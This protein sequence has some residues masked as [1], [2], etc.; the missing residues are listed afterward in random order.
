[1]P[2]AALAGAGAATLTLGVAAGVQALVHKFDSD[3]DVPPPRLPRYNDGFVHT[4][5]S[6]APPA[7]GVSVV[8]VFW[9]TTLSPAARRS[10][11]DLYLYGWALYQDHTTTLVVAGGVQ[12]RP[13]A[14][15]AGA[16][17]LGTLAAEGG[18]HAHRAAYALEVRCTGDTLAWA[19]RHDSGAPRTMSWVHYTP[20]DV[21]RG[22]WLDAAA[23]PPDRTLAPTRLEHLLAMDPARWAE[24]GDP[25]APRPGEAWR[26]AVRRMNMARYVLSPPAT[27]SAV[28][29]AAVL[30]ALSH[31]VAAARAAAPYSAAAHAVA[32]RLAL[33]ESAPRYWRADAQVRRDL[34]AGRLPT[35]PG[36]QT[37]ALVLGHDVSAA[38]LD[39]ALGFALQHV[40]TA[41]GS[42]LAAALQ[43]VAPWL[44]SAAFHTVFAWLVQW[45][46]GIKLN[47]ALASFL[48]DALGTLAGWHDVH[49]VRAASAHAHNAVA[50]SAALAPW[51]GASGVLALWADVWRVLTLHARVL[52]EMLRRA[53]RAMW[54]AAS[55]LFDV[56]RGKKRNPLHGGRLDD[57]EYHVDQLFLGTML[58]TMLVF[59]FPTVQLFFWACAAA[60]VGAEVVH[61]LLCTAARAI[62]GVP[63]YAALV[64]RVALARWADD[65]ALVRHGGAWRVVPQGAPR[66]P[67]APGATWAAPAR[68][69][70]RLVWCALRGVQL[71]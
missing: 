29:L 24:W 17:V 60:W 15:P 55:E 71:P 34:R 23:R 8:R 7:P 31:A 37:A 38:V 13:D 45:P 48:R 16:H 44:G 52:Y 41:R 54:A 22:H 43:R 53:Y 46:L 56:F 58:F 36:L 12:A 4:P 32:L 63:L 51:L 14:L 27:S 6:C 30:D 66:A 21:L 33:L 50:L 42:D 28:P 57:A 18:Y 67:D 35:R 59:L 62:P 64:Q 1:M 2:R 65:V 47:A 61:A 5:L 68:R 49:V 40:L 3:V 26:W 19:W 20:P 9:P 70:P 25:H 69:V 10:A 39:T 11:H